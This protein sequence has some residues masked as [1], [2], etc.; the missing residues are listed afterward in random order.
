MKTRKYTHN[1]RVRVKR[2][3]KKRYVGGVTNT[4]ANTNNSNKNSNTSSNTSNSNS[5]SIWS[6]TS[7]RLGQL[8]NPIANPEINNASTINSSILSIPFYNSNNNAAYRSYQNYMGQTNG[9]NYNYNPYNSQYNNNN[10]YNYTPAT[11]TPYLQGQQQGQRQQ[12]NITTLQKRGRI[13]EMTEAA[14]GKEGRR[15]DKC[16]NPIMYNYEDIDQSHTVFYI[17]NEKGKVQSI[18][19]LDESSLEYYKNSA[20][21]LFHQCTLNTNSATGGL[22]MSSIFVGRQHVVGKPLRKLDF[23]TKAYVLNSEF[24]LVQP[25]GAYMLI[26]TKNKLGRIASEKVLT[27]QNVVSGD[28]CQTIFND[29]IYKIYILDDKKPSDTLL[30]KVGDKIRHIFKSQYDVNYNNNNALGVMVKSNNM[31]KMFKTP[32]NVNYNG[33]NNRKSKNNSMNN[34]N[35]IQNNK[36]GGVTRKY[37]TIKNKSR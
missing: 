17:I 19:C 9:Y 1:K 23:G 25:S 35:Y 16:F 10:N 7:Q 30:Y 15:L 4:N 27:E 12:P 33:I 37:K 6:T 32:Y 2:S 26:P 5:S 3:N 36:I 8:G 13:P 34:N 24:Q 29:P 31:Q 21:Y 22:P 14:F 28:H 11:L 18:A 20:D